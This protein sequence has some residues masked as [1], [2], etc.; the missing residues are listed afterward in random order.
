M[1]IQDRAVWTLG[2]LLIFL[3]ASHTPLYGIRTDDIPDPLYWFRA[4]LAS[5]RG[6]FIYL[7]ICCKFL[8]INPLLF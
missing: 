7:F 8:G 1:N 6:L 3:W 5:N 2:A 4:T